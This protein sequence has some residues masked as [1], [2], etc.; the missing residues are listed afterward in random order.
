MARFC[1]FDSIRASCVSVRIL[2]EDSGGLGQKKHNRMA[3]AQTDSPVAFLDTWQTPT[4]MFID[5]HTRL[6][7]T[8]AFRS[9]PEMNG[10]TPNASS[11]VR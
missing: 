10:A 11:G 8:G 3:K 2:F 9:D 6:E 4:W 5:E 7:A 1:C